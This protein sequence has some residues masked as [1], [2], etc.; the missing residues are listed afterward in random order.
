MV[1]CLYKY[2][3]HIKTIETALFSSTFN[4]TQKTGLKDFISNTNEDLFKIVNDLMSR[5]CEI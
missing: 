3:Y 2:E 5:T 4:M 1:H